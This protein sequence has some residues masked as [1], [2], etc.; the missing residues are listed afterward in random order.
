[1]GWFPQLA[2]LKP[3]A[4]AHFLR[5]WVCISILPRME[6][7]ESN[8]EQ[9]RVCVL[10]HQVRELCSEGFACWLLFGKVSPSL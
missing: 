9:L 6:T 3:L 4:W 10:A 2:A 5:L 7:T 8:I 1:M